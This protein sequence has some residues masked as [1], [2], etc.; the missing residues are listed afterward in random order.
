M[1]GTSARRLLTLEIGSGNAPDPRADVLVD[2]HVWDDSERSRMEPIRRDSRPLIVADGIALPFADKSFDLALAIGVLEHT[3]DPV[4]FLSE[5]SRVAHRGV[6]HVPTTFAERVFY[7]PFHKFTFALDGDTLLI[8]RKSFPD[9]FGGLF[10]YLAHF[11]ADF[12]RFAQN[13]RWLF[14]LT[15]EWEGRAS[16]RLEEYDP[17]RLEFA[18][19]QRTYDG[20]PFK[21]QLCV[22]ELLP[23]QVERLL[24]QEVPVSWRRRVRDWMKRAAGAIGARALP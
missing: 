20:R 16:Y 19:F 7:R 6:V 9:V 8:R 24:A 22:S 17:A 21:F 14:N 3:D 12:V 15:Y 11:D 2:L 5:M 1:S 23:T 18:P 13:H 4:A 10:D